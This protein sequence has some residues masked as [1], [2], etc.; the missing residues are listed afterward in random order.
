M[1]KIISEIIL[2]MSRA[3]KV[4]LLEALRGAIANE[5]AQGAQ[6]KPASCPHCGCPAFV[7]KGRGRHGE[8]RWLCHGCARTFSASTLGLLS[9]S[10]LGAPVWMEFAACMADGLT[11]RESARR[12]GVSLYTAWFMRMRVCEVMARRMPAARAGT[13]WVDETY[14]RES[15]SGNHSRSAWFSMPREAHRNGQDGRRGNV[16]RNK[17]SFSVVCGVNEFGDCF[18]DLA[19]RGTSCSGTFGL[20]VL[21]RVPSGSRLVTDENP[22]YSLGPGAPYEHEAYNSKG[23]GR[24]ALGPVNALHSRLKSFLRRMRG[25]SSRRM[26]RYLDWFCYV[27]HYKNTD[28][29][30]RE[31]LFG[32]EAS[33]RYIYTRS[34]THM[35]EHLLNYCLR[36]PMSTL[37]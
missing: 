32:H 5:L 17:G 2:G 33:G 15:L 9:R 21:R 27:E 20:A 16:G 18:C 3:E 7:R 23:A 24:G 29:D 30:R 6:G 13:F 35:E 37:V 4:E 8:Q 31:L 28:A 14:V 26:Q 12:C 25:V 10:K 36:R 11:L 1:K 22:A 19:E 34:L